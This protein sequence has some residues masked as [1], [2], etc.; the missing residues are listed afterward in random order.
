MKNI[1]ENIFFSYSIE[2]IDEKEPLISQLV[3]ELPLP[4]LSL[5]QDNVSTSSGNENHLSNSICLFL[6]KF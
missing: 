1:H 2:P 5:K 3:D 6:I 4:N